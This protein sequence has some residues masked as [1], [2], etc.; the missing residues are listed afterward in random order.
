MTLCVNPDCKQP[1]NTDEAQ[2]CTS[3]NSKLRLLERYRPIK[4]IGKGGFGRTFLAIDEHKPSKPNCA[5]K[6]LN[7][8][9]RSP[10]EIN[11]PIQLFEQEAVLLEAL[12][13]HPQIPALLASFTQDERLY[14]VQEFIQGVTLERELLEQGTFDEAKIRQLLHDVLTILQFVHQQNVLHRDIKPPNIIIRAKDKKPVL[15]DFGV[16]KIL[17]DESFIEQATA[18]GTFHY[19]AP[20]QFR[21]TV[22]PA[23]DLYSLGVTC[24]HLITGISQIQ[25]MYDAQSLSW[26]WHQ[27]LP[28][29]NI[30]S[31]DLKQILD[32]L[33]QFQPRERYQSAAKVLQA[34]ESLSPFFPDTEIIDPLATKVN[35]EELNSPDLIK[36][37][38]N[39]PIN[40]NTLNNQITLNS[41]N[42]DNNKTN[43]T[44]RLGVYYIKLELLLEA[45]KWKEADLE[46]WKIL[47]MALG[48]PIGTP[49]V[50]SEINSIPCEILLKLDN[51]WTVTSSNRFGFSIQSKIFESVAKDYVTFCDRV[52]WQ[53]YNS[54]ASYH[55]QSL[56]FS[57]NAV[58]GHLPSR[59]WAEGDKFWRH[60]I[61][62][63]SKFS[64]CNS[65]SS[66]T[67]N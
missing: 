6:Q 13:N 31:D 21:G 14:I 15:I 30:I 59:I 33:L 27:F 38:I 22:F 67:S 62:I 55:H 46:T 23:S 2:F 36:T 58:I 41:L 26:M 4:L 10:E 60:L 56:N 40:N 65:Q 50:S 1:N 7:F 49:I 43:Q 24:I 47:C 12:G 39:N 61:A 3:C 9:M 11:K 37:I 29:N 52:K 28:K 25:K 44:S 42:V 54:S 19:A 34:L 32:K 35:I 8:I 17:Q 64:Q 16:A 66:I 20:E 18:L 5:V 63:N 57:K 48:K 53:S 51:I 45:Q